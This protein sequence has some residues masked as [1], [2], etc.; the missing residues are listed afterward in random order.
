MN[1]NIK[2]LT[3]NRDTLYKCITNLKKNLVSIDK[4]LDIFNDLEIYKILKRIEEGFLDVS[5]ITL[6]LSKVL[7]GARLR[8]K[9][10]LILAQKRAEKKKKLAD[11]KAAAKKKAGAKKKGT[12]K[13]KPKGASMIGFSQTLFEGGVS[14]KMFKSKFNKKF[15][16]DDVVSAGKFD[17]HMR[18]IMRAGKHVVTYTF[19]P[20]NET[21][22]KV[23]ITKI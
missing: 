12:T 3:E 18:R 17:R 5:E 16:V 15:K 22:T 11:K 13:P 19:N 14:L 10:E 9:D 20:K 23:Q 4:S 8:Y 6:A 2:L 7:S 1:K 21:K